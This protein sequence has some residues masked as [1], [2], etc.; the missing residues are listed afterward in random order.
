MSGAPSGPLRLA[1][2]DT[3]VATTEGFRR[4]LRGRGYPSGTR[5]TWYALI[6]LNLAI[7]AMFYAHLVAKGG[8]HP[9]PPDRLSV[10][11]NTAYARG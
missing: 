8:L 7:G 3:D 5:Y 2:D 11:A 6:V 10:I 1:I 4:A 9:S